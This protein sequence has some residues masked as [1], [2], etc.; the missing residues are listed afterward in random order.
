VVPALEAKSREEFDQMG[1]PM[2][3]ELFQ[4][5]YLR[6]KVFSFRRI[7]FFESQPGVSNLCFVSETSNPK[8]W[9]SF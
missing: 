3:T 8:T 4:C 2:I 9:R 6:I 1:M 5:F 7:Q